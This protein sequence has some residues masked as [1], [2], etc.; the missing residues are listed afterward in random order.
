MIYRIF[1]LYILHVI[2]F[3]YKLSSVP[4]FTIYTGIIKSLSIYHQ[5]LSSFFAV[6]LIIFFPVVR[7]LVCMTD[8]CCVPQKSRSFYKLDRERLCCTLIDPMFSVIDDM[9]SSL[10]PGSLESTVKFFLASVYKNV[11]F[12]NDCAG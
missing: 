8:V 1:I 11:I 6:N 7:A 12:L 3:T 9:F 10:L 5:S 2:K 4:F